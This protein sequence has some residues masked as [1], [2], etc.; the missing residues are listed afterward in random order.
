MWKCCGAPETKYLYPTFHRRGGTWIMTEILVFGVNC[1]LKLCANIFSSF[2]CLQVYVDVPGGLNLS[3]S[4]P[5][6]IG[7]IPL[8]GCTTR[9]SSISSNCSTLSWL[10]LHERPEGM[11]SKL[12]YSHILYILMFAQY[13]TISRNLSVYC[14]STKLQWSSNIR[15]SKAGLSAGLW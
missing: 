5:L 12:T 8:H 6:V 1:S 3:L 4:L 13:T 11:Y 7:T 2:C 15:G 9:T 14:S 10:G